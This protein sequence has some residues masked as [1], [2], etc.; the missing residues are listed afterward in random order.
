METIVKKKRNR[1]KVAIT[2]EVVEQI[3]STM[4]RQADMTL[5]EVLADMNIQYNDFMWHTTAE[6]RA[7]IPKHRRKRISFDHIQMDTSRSEPVKS[8]TITPASTN[9]GKVNLGSLPKLIY[10][11]VKNSIAI[12]EGQKGRFFIRVEADQYYVVG[13]EYVVPNEPYRHQVDPNL[14]EFNTNLDTALQNLRNKISSLLEKDIAD[15]VYG[16]VRYSL[17]DAEKY[18]S[19]EVLVKTSLLVPDGDYKCNV[20]RDLGQITIN[21][22]S[23][24]FVIAETLPATMGVNLR[25]KD[26][27]GRIYL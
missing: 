20:S 27:I 25:V 7:V 24:A 19:R 13:Y 2:D 21:G 26:N 10:R 14:H 23:I 4:V 1:G 17:A 11:I 22:V 8:I 15:E 16:T 5:K 3:R 12:P 9:E 18:N 6:Q